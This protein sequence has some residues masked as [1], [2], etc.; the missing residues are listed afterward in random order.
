MNF[1]DSIKWMIFAQEHYR[2]AAFRID[3]KSSKF[4]TEKYQFFYSFVVIALVVSEFIICG[5]FLSDESLA[6][7][8]KQKVFAVIL[9]LEY[10]LT[11]I[12]ALFM[13]MS[14][15][16]KRKQQI[17]FFER[18]LNIDDGLMK[19][20]KLKVDYKLFKRVSIMSLVSILVYYNII[21]AGFLFVY[22]ISF[23]FKVATINSYLILLV[24]VIQT[25]ASAIFTHGYVASVYLIYQRIYCVS[26]ELEKIIQRKRTKVKGFNYLKSLIWIFNLSGFNI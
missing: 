17:G 7:P 25:T 8:P 26:E 16:I 3:W 12:C 13:L 9:I 6:L 1:L 2:L 20:F 10:I 19:D 21:L 23:Q 22:R 24:Y 14:A 5:I 11:V 18:I 15:V 4:I